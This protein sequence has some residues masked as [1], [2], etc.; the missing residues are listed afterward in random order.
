MLDR[1]LAR[2][3]LDALDAACDREEALFGVLTGHDTEER[4]VA[5]EHVGVDLENTKLFVLD[6][7][8]A[9]I[10]SSLRKEQ[11]PV[12]RFRVTAQEA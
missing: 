7:F 12:F 8:R 9:S 6:G 2:D 4:H 11:S 10:L 1:Q 3:R 5:V